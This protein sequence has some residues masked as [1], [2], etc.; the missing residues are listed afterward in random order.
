M[1]KKNGRCYVPYVCKAHAFFH[2]RRDSPRLVTGGAQQSRVDGSLGGGG[3]REGHIGRGTVLAEGL[4]PCTVVEL[5]V[6]LLD[7]ALVVDEHVVDA[8]DGELGRGDAPSP[9]DA[10][11]V[12]PDVERGDGNFGLQDTLAVVEG[13][14]GSEGHRA[15]L[16]TESA[17]VSFSGW[18]G[19]YLQGNRP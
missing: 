9:G 14:L 11:A 7:L 13:S 5:G 4:E 10:A 6:V 12:V 19:G 17:M 15:Q 3:A 18:L 8:V 1:P 16:H 2:R